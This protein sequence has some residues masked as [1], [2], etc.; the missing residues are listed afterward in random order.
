MARRNHLD[1]FTRGKMI[2]KLKEGRSL[3]S[4]AEEF[5]INKSAVSLPKH[6][7][8]LTSRKETVNDGSGVVIWRG[9]MLNGWTELHVIDRGSITGDRYCKEM[10]PLHVRL[11]QAAI[12]PDFI[13]MDV[14]AQPHRTA[15]AQQLLE[16]EDIT[17]M[18]W[19]AFSLYLNPIEHVFNI[20]GR[21]LV[22][23]IHPPG[24]T[25]R[26]KRMLIEE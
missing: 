15:D 12:V 2:G 19:P 11:F 8:S 3:T 13:F 4:V 14:N 17:R 18:D 22:A 7:C 6:R 20:L 9:I 26:P 5:G 25:Q 16:S 24:N 21:H 1:I 10:I 23:R